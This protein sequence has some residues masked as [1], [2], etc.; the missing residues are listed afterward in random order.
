MD[1]DAPWRWLPVYD[2]VSEAVGEEVTLQTPRETLLRHAERHGV[3]VD[4]GLERD[5]VFLE[6]LGELQVAVVEPNVV[7]FVGGHG[8][9]LPG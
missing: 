9:S 2:A 3:E 7:S 5:K 6:L 8:A 1:L 4:P